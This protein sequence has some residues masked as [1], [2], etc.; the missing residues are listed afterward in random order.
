MEQA[1]SILHRLFEGHDAAFPGEL[2]LIQGYWAEAVGPLL[3]SRSTPV[4]LV[5]ASLV[6]EA[7]GPAWQELLASV[8][9][10]V[11]ECLRSELPRTPVRRIEIR[12]RGGADP[13]ENEARQ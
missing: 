8:R 12:L 2:D 9:K 7:D 4:R 13:S 5:G 1:K 3:A 11:V 10:Q 6:V